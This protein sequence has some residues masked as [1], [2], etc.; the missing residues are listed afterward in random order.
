MR[1]LDELADAFD[2][3]RSGGARRIAGSVPLVEQFDC[4]LRPDVWNAF[5]LRLRLFASAA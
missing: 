2:A 5:Q 1:I 3:F 4:P